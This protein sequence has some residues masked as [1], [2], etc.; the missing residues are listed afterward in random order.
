MVDDKKNEYVSNTGLRDKAVVF[1]RMSV[2]A[3]KCYGSNVI[4][5]QDYTGAL[6]YYVYF[7][8]TVVHVLQSILIQVAVK[9][10]VKSDTSP[11]ELMNPCRKI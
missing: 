1:T 8:C 5:N 6:I 11:H 3:G 9:T 10:A 4:F 2:N 7:K